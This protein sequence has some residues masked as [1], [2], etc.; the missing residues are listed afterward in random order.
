[1]IAVIAGLGSALGVV[2]YGLF[3]QLLTG[4]PWG[5]KPM[6]DSGLIFTFLIVLV[7]AVIVGGL[8]F[9]LVLIIEVRQEGIRF[10]FPPLINKWKTFK[11]EDI[12][13][14]QVRK[15]SPIWE[16]G[17][18]GIRVSMGKGRAYN[19]RGNKGMQLVMNDGKAILLGTQKGS[20]FM[21]AMDRI[22]KADRD[23]NQD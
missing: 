7:V 3:S 10:R 13:S 9:S 19:V 1:M 15:Y 17:G 14:Y 8:L 12:K 2:G 18:W 16:Y 23:Y 4:E 5:D 22:M 20:E 11:K 21:A 6:S